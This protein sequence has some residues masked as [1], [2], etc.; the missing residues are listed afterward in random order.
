MQT[1]GNQ[2]EAIKHELYET[3]NAERV[4]AKRKPLQKLAL[5]ELAAMD[6]LISGVTKSDATF[7]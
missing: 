1:Q 4:K 2:I 3:L 7:Q 6:L 5:G